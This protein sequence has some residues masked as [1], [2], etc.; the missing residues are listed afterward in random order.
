MFV[1]NRAPALKGEVV[2]G[3]LRVGPSRVGPADE[4]LVRAVRVVSAG[5]WHGHAPA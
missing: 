4:P 1:L 3:L 2:P 5:L